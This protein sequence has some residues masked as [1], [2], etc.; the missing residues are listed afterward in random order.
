MPINNFERRNTFVA[1]TDISGFKVLMQKKAQAWKAL[2]RLYNCGYN[3][4]R[5]QNNRND[6]RVEGFFISDC[7]VLFVRR[8]SNRE[9]VPTDALYS[10][11]QIIKTINWQMLESD[12][13]LTTSIA[14]GEFQY[15]ERIEFP[16]I[17]KNPIYGNAYLSA[18]LDNESGNPKIQPGQ[19]RIV[20]KNLP[21][22][23]EAIDQS[24]YDDIFRII[25]KKDRHYYY[26]WNIND[27]YEIKRFEQD[28][29][30]ADELKYK[31]II[32]LL[33]GNTLRRSTQ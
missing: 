32:K 18:Y 9:I 19:C 13:M 10:L 21:L 5:Q 30:L 11:L 2:D 33:K 31:R 27:P 28:Y 22:E 12:F 14:Y 25:K 3:I 29:K 26:Y 1:Y 20:L 15:I 17:D 23:I 24:Q 4:L 16:G 6:H 7:G 8:L